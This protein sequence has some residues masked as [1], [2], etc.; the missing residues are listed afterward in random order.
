MWNSIWYKLKI[1]LRLFLEVRFSKSSFKKKIA[2]SVFIY[3]PRS[4]G[5]LASSKRYS[6][7]FF[8]KESGENAFSHEPL[9]ISHDGA[10]WKVHQLHF[11]LPGAFRMTVWKF[12]MVMRNHFSRF[13]CVLQPN[14]FCFISHDYAKISHG[15]AKSLFTFPLCAATKPILFHFAW[16]Y[17][18]T[19]QHISTK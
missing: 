3:R 2:P 4:S 18:N 9:A 12:L 10:K 1:I 15:H 6:G 5:H 13:P 14:L 11:R 16:P 17:R 7:D 8:I 19:C